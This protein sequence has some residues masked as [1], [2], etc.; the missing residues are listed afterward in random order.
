MT[1]TASNALFLASFDAHETH[2]L[3]LGE[4]YKP[5]P[6]I[7]GGATLLFPSPSQKWLARL[8]REDML[9]LTDFSESV[10]RV[11]YFRNGRKLVQNH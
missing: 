5:L 8:V 6:Y 7:A 3:S 9:L 11:V 1:E 10:R 4:R 2:P